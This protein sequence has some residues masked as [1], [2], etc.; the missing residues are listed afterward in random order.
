M[1]SYSWPQLTKHTDPQLD[2]LQH[3]RHRVQHSVITYPHFVPKLELVAFVL[4]VSPHWGFYSLNP[5]KHH[6]SGQ[7][8]FSLFEIL[9]LEQTEIKVIIQWK[10]SP[11]VSCEPLFTVS[12]LFRLLISDSIILFKTWAKL[13]YLVLQDAFAT[14][15]KLNS[16]YL[17]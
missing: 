4:A 10:S 16:L 1:S 9:C 12:E 11:L 8:D 5:K 6:K 17:H 14:F 2:P 15:L 13:L 7:N 3:H